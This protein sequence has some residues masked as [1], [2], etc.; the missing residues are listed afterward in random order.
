MDSMVLK[1]NADCRSYISIEEQRS[2]ILDETRPCLTIGGRYSG[3][4]NG[5]EADFEQ[6]RDHIWPWQRKNL[7]ISMNP[8]MG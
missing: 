2:G 5:L 4:F 8:E 7:D 3:F 1:M 6:C